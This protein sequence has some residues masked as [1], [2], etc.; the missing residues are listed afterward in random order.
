MTQV[1]LAD[2]HQVVVVEADATVVLELKTVPKARL[3]HQEHLDTLEK[4]DYLANLASLEVLH[5][6][7]LQAVENLVLHA[8]VDHPDLLV[9][10]DRLVALD[11]MDNQAILELAE[12][13]DKLD[14]LDHLVR[15]I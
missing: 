11:P 8:L 6:E 12:D 10:L 9:H 13:L 14:L 1:S 2:R 5:K 4:T 3:D 15:K 7:K